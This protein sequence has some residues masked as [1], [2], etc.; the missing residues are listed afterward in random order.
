MGTLIVDET[1]HSHA[2]QSPLLGCAN[3]LEAVQRNVADTLPTLSERK[4]GFVNETEPM[5]ACPHASHLRPSVQPWSLAVL[6]FRVCGVIQFPCLSRVLFVVLC[7][8]NRNNSGES[9]RER[10]SR[11]E[12]ERERASLLTAG[13]WNGNKKQF[14]GES[15]IEELCA[16]V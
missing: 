13:S 2:P 14:P 9:Q 3:E 12:R 8:Q 6:R 5:H 16:C 1:N 7:C 11:R 15:G 10:A 4:Q